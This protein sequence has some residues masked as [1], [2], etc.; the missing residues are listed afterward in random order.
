MYLFKNS[1]NNWIFGGTPASICPAG[2]TGSDHFHYIGR[3]ASNE[4]STG[5]IQV[6]ELLLNSINP[7]STVY[8]Q[9][10]AEGGIQSHSS[11]RLFKRNAGI[12]WK[13]AAHN[14]LTESKGYI[15]DAVEGDS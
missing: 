15:S 6:G 10:I 14:Y 3:R 11:I 8:F 12:R 4:I 9:T 13:G 5:W 7:H 1:L 2:A